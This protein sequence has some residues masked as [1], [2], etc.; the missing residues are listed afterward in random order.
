MSADNGIQRAA[1]ATEIENE[2]GNFPFYVSQYALG[3]KLLKNK[4]IV[5]PDAIRIAFLFGLE[6]EMQVELLKRDNNDEIDT[7]E[8]CIVAALEIHGE[9]RVP[10]QVAQNFYGYEEEQK[11]SPNKWPKE[12]TE[13]KGLLWKRINYQEENLTERW[14]PK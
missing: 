5:K 3:Q 4:R 12:G 9:P 13:T 1:H 14:D 8:Q 6:L 10:R 11:R 2:G 7:L